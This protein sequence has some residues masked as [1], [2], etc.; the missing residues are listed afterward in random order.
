MKKFVCTVCVATL[1]FTACLYPASA[2]SKDDAE[3]EAP[4]ATEPVTAVALGDVNGDGAVDAADALRM[5]RHAVGKE[6]LAEE[7][8]AAGLLNEDGAVNATDALLCLQFAVGKRDVFPVLPA[9]PRNTF[10]VQKRAQNGY[11]NWSEWDAAFDEVADRLRQ[12]AAVTVQRTEADDTM[13]LGPKAPTV[14]YEMDLATCRQMARAGWLADLSRS[15]TLCGD[16]LQTAATRSVTVNGKVYGVGADDGSGM[17]YCLCYNMDMLK[18]Y[19]TPEAVRQT[20]QQMAVDAAL[21]DALA[22]AVQ[23]PDPVTQLVED[24]LWNYDAF[25]VLAKV[26]TVDTDGDNRTDVYG[27]TGNTVYGCAQVF[28]ATGGVITEQNGRPTVTGLN[29]QAAQAAKH[30]RNLMK[31]RS[32]SY[33]AATYTDNW[34]NRKAVFVCAATYYVPAFTDGLAFQWHV[35]PLPRR[36]GSETNA[37]CAF[38]GMVWALHKVQ[39]DRVNEAGSL[40]NHLAAAPYVTGAKNRQSLPASA[41]AAC[42]GAARGLLP[43]Y[44]SGV[45]SNSAMQSLSNLMYTSPVKVSMDE[46][47]RQVEAECEAFYARFF[48]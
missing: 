14:L 27:L 36:P 18:Q 42:R 30:S 40:L 12:G 41:A 46:L 6:V 24:G 21:T 13:D 3:I 9:G 10:V 39:A 5:L 29:E 15:A 11:P 1:L 17:T 23:Q 8:L 48:A 35:A 45:M 38:G 33:A 28:C 32:Q 43:D 16:L 7:A 44:A 19:A 20:G 22:A 47:R 25:R 26:C 37:S 31:D 34:R 2:Q 4:M